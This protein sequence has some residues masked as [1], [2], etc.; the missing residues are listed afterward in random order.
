MEDLGIHGKC[1]EAETVTGRSQ[2]LHIGLNR[3]KKILEKEKFKGSIPEKRVGHHYVPIGN[4][5]SG[6]I[7]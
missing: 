5:V 4:T 7:H 3:K 1:E 2:S 6:E